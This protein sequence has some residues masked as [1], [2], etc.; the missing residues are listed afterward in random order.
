MNTPSNEKSSDEQSVASETVVIL[1]DFLTKK[2]EPGYLLSL[3]SRC[4][5]NEINAAWMGRKVFEL[6]AKYMS[7]FVTKG[8][9]RWIAAGCTT[10][11][12][13][14]ELYG[15]TRN[16]YVKKSTDVKET[17]DVKQDY[18]S[19]P[20]L[21][22]SENRGDIHE[23][24][25]NLITADNSL[26][27]ACHK[28]V[29]IGSWKSH[30]SIT[31]WFQLCSITLSFDRLDKGVYVKFDNGLI[32]RGFVTVRGLIGLMDSVMDLKCEP[33]KESDLPK[34]LMV[35][36]LKTMDRK[37]KLTLKHWESYFRVLDALSKKSG[38]LVNLGYKEM[39]LSQT[40]VGTFIRFFDANYIPITE[41]YIDESGRVQLCGVVSYW[42]GATKELS[43]AEIENSDEFVNWLLERRKTPTPQPKSHSYLRAIKTGAAVGVGAVVGVAVVAVV[44]AINHLFSDVKKTSSK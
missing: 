5:R 12:F 17:K 11:R 8:G 22:S 27:Y 32:D 4:S 24:Q 10:E 29:T 15:P 7:D 43:V 23:S 41:F 33:I 40:Y 38:T 28:G 42:T 14:I 31:D 36:S 25:C 18:K 35:E 39:E 13:E 9:V 37:L 3:P 26:K 1:N 44:V 2:I 34:Q 21:F 6:L 30:P 19:E 20:F 16:D